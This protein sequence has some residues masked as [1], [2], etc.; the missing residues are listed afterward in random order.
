M[1]HH[2]D[3]D[4]RRN[5]V[6]FTDSYPYEAALEQTFIE[7][8]LPHLLAAFERVILVPSRKGGIRRNPHERVEV[9]ESLSQVLQR[10][11]SRSQ[12]VARALRSRLFWR[13]LRGSPRLLAYPRAIRR[14]I[15]TVARGGAL[16][17]WMAAWIPNAGLALSETV[18]YS[19]WC[20]DIAVGLGMV[21][22]EAPDLV[23]VA[24]AH[25]ADLYVERHDPPYLACREFL[26]E[27]IDRVYPDS[28]RGAAY[29]LARYPLV[30]GRC[31]VALMGVRD[32]GFLAS[33]S[34]AGTF[35]V[36]SCSVLIPLKRVD[37]ILRGVAEAARRRPAIH[38]RW[39]H[40]GDGE[41][42][43]ELERA[44]IE[45]IPANATFNLR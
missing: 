24:R 26:F 41:L 20:D 44:A 8:E 13:E 39:F 17:G 36:V 3:H 33:A 12:M 16:S 9:D 34:A 29:V 14:L 43:S 10:R 42:R 2:Q 18:A 21:R 35:T 38:V 15:R 27:R 45:L 6:L 19:F 30:R 28:E 22:A 4:R 11:S 7:P 5:V 25:G 23:V 31:E 37:L 1:P 40:F 32:P